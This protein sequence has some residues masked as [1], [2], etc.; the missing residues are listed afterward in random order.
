MGKVSGCPEP[1]QL[2]RQPGASGE[3]TSALLGHRD[4]PGGRRPCRAPA[5]TVTSHARFPSLLSGPRP[6]GEEMGL[7]FH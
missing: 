2:L 6:A 7:R 5:P 3:G 4:H 1:G